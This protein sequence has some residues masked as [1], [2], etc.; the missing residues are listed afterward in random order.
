M[1]KI[2]ES[3]QNGNRKFTINQILNW[4]RQMIEAIFYLHNN[5]VIHRDIKPAYDK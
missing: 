4:T 2:N 5:R 3:I 1:N